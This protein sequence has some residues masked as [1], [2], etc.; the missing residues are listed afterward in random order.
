[1]LRK[2]IVWLILSH[3]NYW[4]EEVQ[5]FGMKILMNSKEVKDIKLVKVMINKVKFKIK[6]ERPSSQLWLDSQEIPSSALKNFISPK[7]SITKTKSQKPK[8]DLLDEKLSLSTR[9][10]SIRK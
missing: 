5:I 4:N 10:R 3:L 2:L 1:M 9:I 8:L 6:E 7:Y